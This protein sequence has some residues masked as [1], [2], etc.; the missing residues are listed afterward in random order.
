MGRISPSSESRAAIAFPQFLQ[1][2]AVFD[3]ASVVITGPDGLDGVKRTEK[4]TV[5]TGLPLR[6]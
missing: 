2:A 6:Q 4:A 5:V 1:T 3:R